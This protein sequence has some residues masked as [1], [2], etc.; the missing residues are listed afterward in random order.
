MKEG[1]PTLEQQVLA[2]FEGKDL[3]VHTL[4][5]YRRQMGHFVRYCR[6][7]HQC[8]TLAE[9]R[10]YADEWLKS[11]SHLS[12]YTQAL[13][14]AS[15]A[16]LYSTTSA[17]F[18]Q[19]GKRS[20]DDLI[21][22]RGRKSRDRF[23][24]ETRN[25]DFV[26]FCRATGLTRSELKALTGDQLKIEGDN[27]FIEM[28]CDGENCI[29]KV[30]VIGNTDVVVKMMQAAGSGRVF[31]KIFSAADIQSYRVDYARSLYQM[32]ARD[33]ETCL[34]SPFTGN[35]HSSGRGY[36][37]SVYWL[38]GSHQGEWLDKQAM[39]MATDALGLRHFKSFAQSYLL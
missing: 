1:T 33:L 2:V 18:Y 39:K 22:S 16:R 11:R 20:R 32:H 35:V 17:D 27:V 24:S 28:P 3:A 36:D 31:K 13:D 37:N 14:V 12:R 25:R 9:C 5:T 7:H 6:E 10:P 4:N 15:L 34:K 29:R 19:S 26:D 30:P 38:R 21:R 23:F 8:T